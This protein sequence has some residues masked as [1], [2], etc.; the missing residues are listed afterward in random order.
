M[1]MATAEVITDCQYSS[2]NKKHFAAQ[3][4][5]NVGEII[6]QYLDDTLKMKQQR[7]IYSY[8]TDVIKKDIQNWYDDM[9][10]LRDCPRSKHANESPEDL[11]FA[12]PGGFT[13][14]F[15]QANWHR[16]LRNGKILSEQSFSANT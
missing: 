4:L 9:W 10:R 14:A 1:Q 5:C 7:P 3:R 2:N 16:K 11:L 12:Q 15:C 13:K 6:T 8:Y